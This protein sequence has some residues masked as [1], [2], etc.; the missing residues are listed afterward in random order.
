MI[1]FISNSKTR[2]RNNEFRPKSELLFGVHLKVPFDLK[3]SR[4]RRPTFDIS[5]PMC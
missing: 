3:R 5:C 1:L 4:T 2:A